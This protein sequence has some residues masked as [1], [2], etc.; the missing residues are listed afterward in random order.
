L[1]QGRAR[2]REISAAMASTEQA[3]GKVK[4][5][6]EET[7]REWLSRPAACTAPR[8]AVNFR[9]ERTAKAT[10]DRVAS[11]ET[12]DDCPQGCGRSRGLDRLPGMFTRRRPSSLPASEQAA[13]AKRGRARSRASNHGGAGG[14]ARE[15]D[16][17]RSFTPIPCWR[18]SSG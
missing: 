13:M 14:N 16:H 6:L 8:S 12:L 17:W 18:S 11:A 1:E 3:L 10:N 7:E 9:P 2:F 4:G 5:L 15:S